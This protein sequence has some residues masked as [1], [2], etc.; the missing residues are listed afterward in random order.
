MNDSYNTHTTL[1]EGGTEM[2]AGCPA[3][4]DLRHPSSCLNRFFTQL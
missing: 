2:S 4:W 1:R 3:S